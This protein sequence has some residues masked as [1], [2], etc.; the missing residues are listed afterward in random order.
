M[1]FRVNIVIYPKL[2][3]PVSKTLLLSGFSTS[4]ME[5]V[6]VFGWLSVK[7]PKKPK[8]I[9]LTMRKPANAIGKVL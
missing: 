6:A 5:A 1:K 4:N 3:V 2:L 8:E 9:N 7:M